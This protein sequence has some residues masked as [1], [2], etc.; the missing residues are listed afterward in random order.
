MAHILQFSSISCSICFPAFNKGLSFRRS[1]F[2]VITGVLI[3]KPLV[4]FSITFLFQF[5]S[6]YVV[7]ISC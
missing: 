6:V 2:L 7:M 1:L 4:W 5:S 3:L